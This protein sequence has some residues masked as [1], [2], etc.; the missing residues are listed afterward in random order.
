MEN[1]KEIRK[2]QKELSWL[3]AKK[4]SVDTNKICVGYLYESALKKLNGDL[5]T[6][7]AVEY[8]RL[9][10]QALTSHT[11]LKQLEDVSNSLADAI[12]AAQVQLAALGAE[13]V[14]RKRISEIMMERSMEKEI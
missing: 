9:K 3:E 1:S 6:M 13:P 12:Y 7:S 14:R 10:K 5:N 2:L 4:R 8:I 11:Q